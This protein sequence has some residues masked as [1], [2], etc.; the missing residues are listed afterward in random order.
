LYFNAL[1]NFAKMDKRWLDMQKK[2]TETVI[3]QAELLGEQAESSQ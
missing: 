2:A 1:D 3:Q